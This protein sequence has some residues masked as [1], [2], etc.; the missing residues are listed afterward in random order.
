MIFIFQN[1]QSIRSKLVPVTVTTIPTISKSNTVDKIALISDAEST[2][3]KQLKLLIL[4]L[5]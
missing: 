4:M 2:L 5:K 1:F 3:G